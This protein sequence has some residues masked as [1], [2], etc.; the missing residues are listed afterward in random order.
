MM[1][2]S[3]VAVITGSGR[4]IGK[5]IADRLGHD[6]LKIVLNDIDE[7]NLN[8]AEKEFQ[9]KNIEVTTFVGD[10]TNLEDQENLMQHA[11]NE[12]GSLDVFVNNAG[13]E[14][15]IG[16]IYEVEPE[17]IDPVF[18]INIKGVIYGIRA[19]ANQMIEQGNGGKIVNAS[20]IGGKRGSEMLGLYSASKFAVTAL[21][22]TAALELAQ[23]DILVNAYAPAMVDTGMWD[24]IDE[25]MMEHMGTEKGEFYQGLVDSIPLGR[26]QDPEEVASL[27]SFLVSDDS[28]FITGQTININGGMEFD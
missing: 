23:H 14:G 7:D 26:S 27:V 9:D 1:S 13:I 21:T 24:R 8:E 17:D 20:S 19:A 3:E 6:G 2:N 25:A 11:V 18:D 4:G 12:F 5:L 28:D 10:V 15:A 16:P 22:Q